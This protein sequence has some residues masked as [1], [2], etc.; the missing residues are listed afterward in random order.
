MT[1]GPRLIGRKEA[2]A[3]LG[4]AESPFSM[5]VATHKMPPAIAGTRKWDRRAID[6]KLDEISGLATAEKDDPYEKWMR[7]NGG[8]KRSRSSSAHGTDIAVWR[9]DKEKRRAKYKPQLG[10]SGKIE[11]ALIFMATHPECDTA[12]SIP[13]AGQVLLDELIAAGA[14]R[15]VGTEKNAFR[16]SLTEEGV[17]EA[18]RI[19]KWRALSPD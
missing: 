10:L 19:K 9:A 7:E 15:L 2:A 3:Y 6:A 4:I 5:W 1:D 14:A 18:A 17:A 11:T 13:G 16:Y 8:G 12:A